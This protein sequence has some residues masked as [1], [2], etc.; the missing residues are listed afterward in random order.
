MACK[1]CKSKDIEEL[2]EDGSEKLPKSYKALI[3]IYSLLCAYGLI[4]LIFDIVSL[5][6]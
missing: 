3:L 1:G 2:I 4:S 6:N 5:F